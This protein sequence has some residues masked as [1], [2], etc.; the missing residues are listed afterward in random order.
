[1]SE[2]LHPLKLPESSPSWTASKRLDL[3]R[4][5][6]YQ[7]C[8]ADLIVWAARA[9]APFGQVPAHHHAYLLHELEAVARGET[10]RLSVFM[11]PG[12]AKTRYSSIVFPAWMIAQAQGLDG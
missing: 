12:H 6:N 4:E 3:R 10:D 5:A 7:K 9:L 2:T 1:M 8:R 11:P